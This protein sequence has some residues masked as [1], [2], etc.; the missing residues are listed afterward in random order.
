VSHAAI[1]RDG[2]AA[3]NAV[4]H[5]GLSPVT[6]MSGTS[7]TAPAGPDQTGPA[8]HDRYFTWNVTW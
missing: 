5:T 1:V 6:K 8:V 2:A 3:I 4:R 7:T